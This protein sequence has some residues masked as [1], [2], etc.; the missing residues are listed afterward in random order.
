MPFFILFFLIPIAEVFVFLQ[1][2]DEIGIL[3]TLL[4]C[5]LTAIIGGALV[6]HQGLGTLF[7][8]RAE[9]ND[10]RLPVTEL[11]DGLCLVAAGAM[12]ITPG[13]VTDTIGFALLVPAFREVLR[14][15]AA[16]HF[17][18]VQTATYDDG[19]VE[20]EYVRVERETISGA[21]KNGS[22]H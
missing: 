22:P 4:L 6:R 3:Q 13:F 14:H 17:K 12:L 19:V 20:G 21:D 1:V 11:F 7:R 9:M 8:A 5:L 16:R 2:G 10:G 15:W 18:L